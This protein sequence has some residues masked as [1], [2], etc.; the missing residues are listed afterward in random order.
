MSITLAFS[1][2]P[3]SILPAGV[4]C[5]MSPNFFRCTLED[6]Y[7]QCSLH[8]TEYIASSQLVGRRFRMLRIRWYSSRF[9]PSSAHGCSTSGVLVALLTVSVLTW[10]ATPVLGG[11]PVVRGGGCPGQPGAPPAGAARN[12]S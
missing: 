9:S 10:I 4:S 7:E 2:I 3:A 6:L 1:P 11:S 5:G 12:R 8:I